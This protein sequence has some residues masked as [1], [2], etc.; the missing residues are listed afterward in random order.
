[1]ALE[2]ETPPALKS[3]RAT[4]STTGSRRFS[5][6]QNSCSPRE[7]GGDSEEPGRE[8]ARTEPLLIAVWPRRQHDIPA[9]RDA[10]HQTGQRAR[11]FR[12]PGPE[13]CRLPC[14]IPLRLRAL[15]SA[16]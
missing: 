12:G 3:V 8:E 14:A 15:P 5:Y 2:L 11:F 13:S 6:W 16:L 7:R 10:L 9:P 4:I 1:M